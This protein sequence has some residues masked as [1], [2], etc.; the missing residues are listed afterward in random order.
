MTIKWQAHSYSYIVIQT[1]HVYI[2]SFCQLTLQYMMVRPF[3]HTHE[4]RFIFEERR[5]K[6]CS[7]DDAWFSRVCQ[8]TQIHRIRFRCGILLLLLYILS[9]HRQHAFRAV[10]FLHFHRIKRTTNE[11]KIPT[12]HWKASTNIFGKDG[13]RQPADDI[14]HSTKSF[15]LC[16]FFFI[17]F[18]IYRR[19]AVFSEPYTMKEWKRAA[20]LRLFVCVSRVNFSFLF[21]YYY[22][23]R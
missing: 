11:W 10:F 1:C 4:P 8:C 3:P 5:K 17:H 15:W 7:T 22:Q 21:I 18:L 12:F 14:W 16:F 6:N 23:S 2:W 9:K 19:N 13:K 20:F